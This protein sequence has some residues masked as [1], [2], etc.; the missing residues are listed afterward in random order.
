MS[1]TV[2]QLETKVTSAL[3]RAKGMMVTNE[4]QYV[5]VASFLKVIKGLQAEVDQTHDPVVKHWHEKH[6]DALA[7]KQRDL[8]PLLDAEKVLKPRISAYLTEQERLRKEAELLAQ[9]RAQEEAEREQ[10][11]KAAILD[12]LGETAL[13][14]EVLEEKPIVVPV[15]LPKATPRVQGISMTK[16]YSATVVNLQKLVL[17]VAAGKAPIQCLQADQVFLNRQATAM[18]EAFN[19]PGVDLSV[20]GNIS[21][22]P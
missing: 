21:A 16:R 13:A 5:A 19:Y 3:E 14:N 10:L 17:A 2:E 9:K 15:I 1:T 18:K 8:A 11:E 22:R 20:N 7:E 12:D 6:K 4:E